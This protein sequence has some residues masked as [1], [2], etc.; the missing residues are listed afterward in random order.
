MLVGILDGTVD[1]KKDAETNLFTDW[2]MLGTKVSGE[3]HERANTVK[4][5]SNSDY[6]SLNNGIKDAIEVRTTPRTKITVKGVLTTEQTANLKKAEQEFLTLLD[7]VDAE[8]VTC[9]E[10]VTQKEKELKA[11]GITLGMT[12]GMQ[13][14]SLAKM[15]SATKQ[16]KLQMK[17]LG[18]IQKTNIDIAAILFPGFSVPE[19][20]GENAVVV[21][22]GGLTDTTIERCKKLFTEIYEDIK[23]NVVYAHKKYGL[24]HVARAVIVDQLRQEGFTKQKAQHEA[25][26]I[27]LKGSEDPIASYILDEKN[28]ITFQR[29]IQQTPLIPE[30]V[31]FS[32][33]DL[34]RL[35]GIRR[36]NISSS[37]DKTVSVPEKEGKQEE[38]E[39]EVTLIQTKKK[40]TTT[41]RATAVL[42]IAAVVIGTTA[43]FMK[44]EIMDELAKIRSTTRRV[45]VFMEMDLLSDT[46]LSNTELD[47]VDIVY[48]IWYPIAG[49]ISS[50]KASNEKFP[51]IHIIL[52]VDLIL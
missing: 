22:V 19:E 35:R 52:F 21:V 4:V 33:L 23:Q 37:P 26:A 13:E 14:L 34:D 40:K 1:E 46:S 28:Y 38:E 51:S 25:S 41:T 45:V 32:L 7:E 31:Q 18:M 48:H 15:E 43:A 16:R 20:E 5:I 10:I 44:Q 42:Q 47:R 27:L 50:I 49:D 8:I 9:K 6:D 2:C 24:S 39:E 36:E 17:V 11:K 12:Q 30:K 29:P 3:T